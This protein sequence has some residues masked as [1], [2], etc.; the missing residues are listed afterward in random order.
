MEPRTKKAVL[1]IIF[2]VLLYAAAM[3]FKSVLVFCQ[4]ALSLFFPVLLGFIIA[5]ILNVPMKGFENLFFRI[6]KNCSLGLI[7]VFSLV[8]TLF[9]IVL[10]I[11]I[12]CTMVIPE[13]ADSA[14]SI[15][16]LVKERWPE[17]AAF[18]RNY[19]IDLSQVSEWLT[20]TGIEK[21]T[22]NAGFLLGSVLNAATTT[23]Y[24]VINAVF[25]TVIAIYILLNKQ[26]L[27]SQA[28]KLV[29]ANVKKTSAQSFFRILRLIRETYSKFLSGQC[30]EAI[31]L[32]CLMF[33]V[34]S[35]FGLPY[36]GI[37]AFLTGL[38]AFVPFV[39][40]FAACIIGAFLT[41]LASPSQVIVCVAVYMGVQF[42]ENQLIYPHV[43]GNSVGLSPLWTLVA[44]LV[45]GKLFGLPG[46]LFFIP[47]AA[48]MYTLIR[49]NTS[50]KLGGKKQNAEK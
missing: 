32:G 15:Y 23:I 18:L 43:V 28:K 38:F 7:R 24:G 37:I 29:Y 35:L 49:E 11:A 39:G 42:I 13:L 41:L 33:I 9:S 2:G 1:L 10:V 16:P 20:D 17:W 40:A 31:I 50:R 22:S 12:A 36:A 44:A 21:L 8:L 47:L 25:A 34:F 3:N 6:K 4:N 19:H 5:F 46:I 30:V 14:K 45:G 26:V 27:S 48:V